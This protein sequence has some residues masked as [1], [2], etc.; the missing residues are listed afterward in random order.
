ML[1]YLDFLP[2]KPNGGTMTPIFQHDNAWSTIPKT[3][4]KYKC[5]QPD[6]YFDYSTDQELPSF[7]FTKNIK[8]LTITCNDDGQ[9]DII[10][11][12]LKIFLGTKIKLQLE[13]V[14]ENNNSYYT[15]DSF[16]DVS[17]KATV[18]PIVT[19]IGEQNDGS[20]ENVKIP[21][22][23]DRTVRCDV[24]PN[25]NSVQSQA[26]SPAEMNIVGNAPNLNDLQELGTELQ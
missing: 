2:Q 3:Q 22:C 21:E 12:N 16:W 19:C 14:S 10:Y 6:H 7:H 4:I 17:D 26:D 15:S 5:K 25:P 20:C 9:V 24:I 11:F 18:E 1:I 8:E 23:K 13:I